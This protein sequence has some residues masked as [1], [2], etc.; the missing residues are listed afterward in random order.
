[1]VVLCGLL[2]DD[3]RNTYGTITRLAFEHGKVKAW[4]GMERNVKEC[5][6]K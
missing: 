6:V 2:V 4:R 1:M 5:K 3:V